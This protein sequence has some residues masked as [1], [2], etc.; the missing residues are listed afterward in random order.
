MGNGLSPES[1]MENPYV[2]PRPFAEEERDLF[3]GREREARDLL[4]LVMA[5]RLVLF[6]AQSGAGKSSLINTRLVVGLRQEGFEVLPI[7][8]VSGDL[9]AGVKGVNNIFVFNLI[10]SVDQNRHEAAS[11]TGTTLSEYLQQHQAKTEDISEAQGTPRVLIIDQ[12]EEMFTTNLQHWRLRESFFRQLGEAISTDTLLWVVL[13]LREDYV[14]PLAPFTQSLPGKLRTR[15]YMRRLT[16]TAALEAIQQ[17]AERG[18]RP[19]APGVAE[20]LVDNLRQIRLQ[21]RENETHLGEFVEPVQLQVV[22]YQLWEK[23]KGQ[24]PGEITEQDLREAGDVDTA[25]AEFYEQAIRKTLQQTGSSEIELRNWFEYQLITEAGTRGMVY[26][27]AEDSAGLANEAVKLLAD[28]FLLRAEVRAAGTWYEL[29]HD[30][31]IQPILKANQAWWRQQNPLIQAARDWDRSGR[32]ED[33]LYVG[34]QLMNALADVNR[35]TLDPLVSEFLAASEA[36]NRSLEEQMRIAQRLS[37]LSSWLVVALGAMSCSLVGLVAIL[38]LSLGKEAM[39][40]VAIFLG[41]LG[42][43]G[44]VGATISWLGLWL[45]RRRA[46]SSPEAASPP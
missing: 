9:P 18:G 40:T 35:E 30:R 13:T 45:Y 16:H 26:Q 41:V 34:H 33:K 4:S 7:G 27:G 31:F 36:A 28:Q 8:R 11:F 21:G 3:F 43:P 15:F 14:A 24:A 20:T 10:L 44:M 5:D 12:F 42:C 1:T 6:Y 37:R 17:P 19:F 38:W 29:I 2:G 39:A 25:L 23:L 46:R 32:T 22:C